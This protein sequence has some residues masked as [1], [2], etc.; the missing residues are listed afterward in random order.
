MNVEIILKYQ[1][2]A[3][4]MYAFRA[5]W[6]KALFTLSIIYGRYLV[7]LCQFWLVHSERVHLSTMENINARKQLCSLLHDGLMHF[8]MRGDS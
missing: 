5:V 6:Q 2:Q 8:T 7:K 3:V 1:Q 4:L